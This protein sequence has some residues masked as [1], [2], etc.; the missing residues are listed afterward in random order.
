MTHR[1]SI[2]KLVFRVINHLRVNI[3]DLQATTDITERGG[4]KLENSF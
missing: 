4:F 2:F 3:V 1:V